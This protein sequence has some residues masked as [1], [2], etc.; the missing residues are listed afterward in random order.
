LLASALA[1]CV[2]QDA[3][4]ETTEAITYNKVPVTSNPYTLFETLQV[5]P[6]AMS[7]DG[8]LLFACNTPDNRLQVYTVSGRTI[9]PAGGAAG[10]TG[11]VRVGLEPVAVAARSQSEVWVVNHL[12]DSVSIVD[13]ST[14]A[15]PQ[16]TNTLF[17]GDEPRDIVFANGLAF[18]TTAHRGQNSPDDPDLFRP[19]VGRADV[20]VFDPNNLGTAMG[21]TRKTKITLF[22]DTPRALTV[23]PDG[24]TVYAAAFFSGNQTTSVTAD[25]VAAVY[26]L[27]M[28]PPGATIP[29]STHPQ[30]ATGL[31]VK[32]TN[33]HWLDA[34]GTSFDAYVNIT[35]PDQDVFAIDATANPPVAKPTGI[36][37]HVG[38]TLFNMATNPVTGKIY[39]TNTDAHNDVRF[40]GHTPGFS[41]VA[42]NIVDSRVSVL[43]PSAM[44]VSSANLNPHL[45][46]QNN[47]GDATLSLAFPMG[48]AVSA[49]G[50]KLYTVGQGS[51]KLAMY[52]TD[53][54]ESGTVSPSAATQTTLTGGGS[55]GLVLDEPAGIAF[56]LTR[57]D[58]GISVVDLEAFTEL[59][60][61]RMFNPE[62]AVVTSGRKFLYDATL[63]SKLGD[64]ACSSCHIGGDFDGLAWDLGNPGGSEL[65]I[66]T[67]YPSQ[68]AGLFGVNGT[69]GALFTIDKKNVA[70][71]TSSTVETNLFAAYQPVKGPMTTQSL[72]GLDNHGAMH[73]RGDRNGAIQQSGLPFLDSSGKPVVTKQPN[74]GMFDEL[75]AFKS[76]NV[77]FPGLVGANAQLSDADMTSY[78]SFALQITY[79]PNPI[80][81]L[82]DSLT[83]DQ[84]AGANFF[85]Q[86]VLQLLPPAII[87]E[88]VDTFHNCIGCHDLDRNGNKGSTPH[89]GFF[90]TDGRISYDAEAQLLKVPHLRNMYQKLGM[91]TSKTDRRFN[92]GS[93]NPTIN[94]PSTAV[95]GFGFSHDGADGT[96]EQ[97][98]TSVV[99]LKS[100]RQISVPSP[101]TPDS[102]TAMLLLGLPSTLPI[103]VTPGNP[104]GI[105]LYKDDSNPL[106]AS[107][108]I[109]TTGQTTRR[110]LAA[111]VLAFDS[112]MKPVV[113]QQ[114]ILT[115]SNGS[116]VS[117]RISL[118]ERQAGSGSPGSGSCDLVVRGQAGGRE[119][120]WTY[121][122]GQFRPDTTG[123]AVLSD[124]QIR[125]LPTNGGSGPLTFSCVPPGSGWR[126][127]IDRDG[128]TFADGDEI[129]AGT[130]PADPTSHP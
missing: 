110:Q 2:P 7:P 74:G 60:H 26:N 104:G 36:F 92:P 68:S 76:F 21:G 38:T 17:V 99:F 79:P 130:N 28:P 3:S 123:A 126:V 46:H 10:V 127:G 44:A 125:A 86:T 19:G 20:W 90:G 81:N 55:T 119:H 51:S 27:T 115:S 35:L 85:S 101:V 128:D 97:F 62:P 53:A 112:N 8:T 39:V 118:F 49:D 30:A 114:V 102:A 12:S 88:P 15:S 54:I 111:Y 106:N 77:A 41:S 48:V 32:Y 91:Y 72:R 66:T 113:G 105:Q 18:I 65:L 70:T 75:N 94:P 93:L 40:E 109:S 25:N 117:S 45:D 100:N 1:A 14:P 71:G 124:S 58:N 43:D 24:R 83:S 47:T 37:A 129:A 59:S 108:G 103:F 116:T 56:V 78:A 69:D 16:V 11:A 121:S 50:T 34:Y 22:A 87:E 73:W 5:R 120:G 4:L 29:G 95:R 107:A 9:A 52:P 96:I 6:L 64:Q 13:V 89:P 33:G 82:D 23:S 61:T 84:Q 63:T 80:H 98:L 122:S 67:N 57:F 42:G 31:I